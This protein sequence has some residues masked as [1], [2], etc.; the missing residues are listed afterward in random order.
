MSGTVFEFIL[1]KSAVSTLPVGHTFNTAG[2]Q[3][4][5]FSVLERLKAI[6]LINVFEFWKVYVR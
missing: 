6:W 4:P 5:D 1:A 3:I 2:Y